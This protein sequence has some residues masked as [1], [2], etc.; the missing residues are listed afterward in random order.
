MESD[1]EESTGEFSGACGGFSS[2]VNF[3]DAVLKVRL[4]DNYELVPGLRARIGN[5]DRRSALITHRSGSRVVL[6]QSVERIELEGS[7][8]RRA[9]NRC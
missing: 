7:G 9:G 2:K 3:N 5:A 1:P 8:L 6:L 4:R